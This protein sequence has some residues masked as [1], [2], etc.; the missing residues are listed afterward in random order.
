[1]S[2]KSLDDLYRQGQTDNWQAPA[3]TRT[4]WNVAGE[5]VAR[6]SEAGSAILDV[7][8]FDGGFLRT[9]DNRHG[10]FGIEIH[11]AARKK[12]EASGIQIIGNDFDNIAE[13][14]MI[15]DVVTSFDVIEHTQNPFEFLERISGMTKSGGSIIFSTGNTDAISWRL[16]GSRYWYC[17]I[18]EHLSFINPKWCEWAGLKL[19]LELRQI[20]KFSHAPGSWRQRAGE[21]LKNLL[22]AASPTFFGLLRRVGMGGAEYR[23][24]KSMLDHPPNWMS[25]KDH[26]ICI[27]TK[28]CIET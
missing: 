28:K 13:Q 18:G 21:V 20:V 3:T 7:G 16:L 24:H 1:M 22:Y 19:G 8:C 6:Y 11:E 27:Y 15:F 23:A 10:H 25:A 14:H 5:W 12:A 17:T 9:I 4:D 2:K 26:F